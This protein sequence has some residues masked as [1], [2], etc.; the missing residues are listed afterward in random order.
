MEAVLPA[1]PARAALVNAGTM[2][3]GQVVCIARA[4]RC[5]DCPVRRSCAWLEAGHPAYDGPPRRGQA[6]QGTDR[7]CRGRIMALARDAHGTV[8]AAAIEPAWP[9]AAQRDRCLASLVEVG[10]LVT[11]TTGYALP[12]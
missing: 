12:G 2:E 10:L 1:D 3:L 4:P 11:A 5:D 9:E 8:S 7:Q 6:W